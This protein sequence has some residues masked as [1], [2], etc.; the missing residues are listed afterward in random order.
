MARNTNDAADAANDGAVTVDDANGDTANSDTAS[1]GDAPASV[2][3]NAPAA[4]PGAPLGVLGVP[5][6]NRPIVL[7]VAEVKAAEPTPGLTETRAGGRFVV[8]GK[9][10]DAHGQPLAD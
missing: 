8:K 6:A 3:V 5:D 7:Q 9:T 2:D 4:P 1:T 10:V